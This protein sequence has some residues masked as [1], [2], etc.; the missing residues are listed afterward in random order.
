MEDV[1]FNVLEK[2]LSKAEDVCKCE[3][4]KLDIAAIALNKLTP[5]YVVTSKGRVYT[6][7][8][9]LEVQAVA[10]VTREITKAVEI[11]KKHPQH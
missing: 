6:K 8:A 11:V 4:C 9:E 3:K 2:F 10:D 7:I 1:V 5:K